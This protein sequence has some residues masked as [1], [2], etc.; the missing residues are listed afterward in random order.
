MPSSS[1]MVE[2]HYCGLAANDHERC[3]QADDELV[4]AA[5]GI[6]ILAC[7]AL[8]RYWVDIKCDYATSSPY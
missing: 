5:I 4:Q 3:E 8:A 1:S 7:A 2:M 6:S